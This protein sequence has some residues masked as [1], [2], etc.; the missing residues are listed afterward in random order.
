MTIAPD[1]IKAAAARELEAH[2]TA[3]DGKPITAW[4]R[5]A[6]TLGATISEVNAL[7]IQ[8]DALSAELEA[9]KEAVS[10]IPF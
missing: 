9:V 2:P 7:R 6:V 8:V 10:S 5:R 1:G 3:L 4:D